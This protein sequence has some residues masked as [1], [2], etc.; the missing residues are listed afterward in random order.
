MRLAGLE[1]P[2]I[3]QFAVI[4][5]GRFGSSVALTLAS[6]GYDVLGIDTD[7]DK[8][9]D[10]AHDIAHVV[11]G[12]ATDIEVL[13]TLGLRNFD[14]AVVAIGNDLQASILVTLNLKEL[15]VRCVVS[16]ALSEVHGKLLI[17]TGADRVVFP[18][19]DMGIRVANNLL[20]STVMEH[21]QLSPDHSIAE[22]PATG[23]LAGKTLSQL[24]LRA[25][26][27]VNIMAIRRGKNIIVSPQ[28]DNNV[29][30]GDVLIVIG[31]NEGIRKLEGQ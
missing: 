1:G 3:K 25:R 8:V 5:L 31:E 29:S 4:G 30:P 18:E 19:R 17:K 6:M 16:K 23:N 2:K 20:A 13:K 14:V 26:F 11:E 24:H 22:V 15:G 9:R 10:M 21:I 12:D 7:P 27:G 28:A